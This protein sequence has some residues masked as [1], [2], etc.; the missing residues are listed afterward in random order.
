MLQKTKQILNGIRNPQKATKMYRTF[1]CLLF[2]VVLIQAKPNRRNLS[3]NEITESK[4]SS[5]SLQSPA[6]QMKGKMEGKEFHNE[7]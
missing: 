5:E 4:Y 7:I 3:N 1:S 2:F 6:A